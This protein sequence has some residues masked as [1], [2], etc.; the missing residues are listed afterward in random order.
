MSLKRFVLVDLDRSLKHDAE[1]NAVNLTLPGRL[2]ARQILVDW[3]E[4]DFDDDIIR[5]V[6]H[7]FRRQIPQKIQVEVR[8]GQ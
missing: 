6:R 8:C 3:V 5:W 1:E 2:V 4:K 7:P